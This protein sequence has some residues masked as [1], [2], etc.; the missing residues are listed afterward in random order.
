MVLS[1]AR[2]ELVLLDMDVETVE[3]A[4]DLKEVT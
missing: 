4:I 2:G 3:M 1:N